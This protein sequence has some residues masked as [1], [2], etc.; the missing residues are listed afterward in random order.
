MDKFSLK[1]SQEFKIMAEGGKKLH[2]IK[3]TLVDKAKA[4]VSALEIDELAEK[5]IVNAG[6]E[7]SFK[8]VRGY[9]WSTC[10]NINDGVVHGIP[11]KEKVFKDG[12]NA[13]I[14]VG[15]YFKGFHLILI[16]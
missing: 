6:G 8:M 9:S 3:L 1:T 11:H 7:P 13:S 2:E 5:L 4:G 14:D 12:D 16:F 10:I 15:I